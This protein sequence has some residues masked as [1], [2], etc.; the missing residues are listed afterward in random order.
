MFPL[1]AAGATAWVG[2]LFWP[3]TAGSTART[4]NSGKAL[5]LESA[6]ST[7]WAKIFCTTEGN[8]AEKLEE[9][10]GSADR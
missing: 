6:G 9:T 4:G 1:E 5:L 10:A 8:T 2:K 7:A 3:R